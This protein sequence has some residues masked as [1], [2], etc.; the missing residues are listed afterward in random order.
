MRGVINKPAVIRKNDS[1]NWQIEFAREFQISFIMRGY[2]LD[3]AGAVA[4]QNVIRNPDRNFFFVRRVDRIS[5]SEDA[6]FVSCQLGALEIAFAC[7]KRAVPLNRSLLLGRRDLIDQFV[8]RSQN[9]IRGA[10]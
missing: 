1:F 3:R 8:F 7:R 4:E 5:A 10:K 6:G 9:H 2:G